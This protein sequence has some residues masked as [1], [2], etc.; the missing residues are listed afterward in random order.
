MDGPRHGPGESAVEVTDAA[1]FYAELKAFEGRSTGPPVL[2]DDP[3]NVPMVRHWVEA[4]GDANPVYLDEDAARRSVH[5]GVVAPPVMLQAWCMKGL[6]QQ[7]PRTGDSAQDQL[8]QLLDGAGFTSV[9]ATNSEQEYMRYLRPGDHL[10]M[11]ST[12][13]S[14]SEEKTTALGVGHFVTNLHEYRDQHGE[15]VG[16]MRFRILKFRPGPKKDASRGEEHPKRPRPATTADTLFWFEG[17]KRHELLIQRCAECG[18]L[19][20]PPGPM[21]PECRS[22]EWDTQQATGRGTVYS[23]VVNHH[24]QVPGFDYPLP[25]V[26]VQ[27]EEGTR[28]VSNIVGAEPGEIVIGMPVE[29][30]FVEFD[31]ELTLPQFRPAP[32]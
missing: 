29:V 5:G 15:L 19:R 2:G 13:E 6:K 11:T 12:I 9:V 20:H 32:S 27:L 25:V 8:M 4:N 31:D 21:C 3:V 28:I 1:A 18:R 17:A 14:V 7:G 24:P 23:F 26:L 22:L 16:T 10:T 30:E